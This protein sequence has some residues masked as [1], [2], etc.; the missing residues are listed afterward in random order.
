MF[1]LIQYLKLCAFVNEGERFS[2][3][4]KERHFLTG[5]RRVCLQ[6][7]ENDLGWQ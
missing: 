5:N 6:S 3:D 4:M 7:L 1:Q 2:K